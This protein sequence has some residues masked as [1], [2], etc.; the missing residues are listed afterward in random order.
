MITNN[1]SILL[2]NSKT[3]CDFIGNENVSV[4]E[5]VKQPRVCTF[6]P[7]KCADGATNDKP[8]CYIHVNDQALE[9]ELHC[10]DPNVN[11][12]FE[13]NAY[14]NGKV[15]SEYVVGIE[16]NAVGKNACCI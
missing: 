15:M 16:T 10:Y 13:V 2:F 7:T 12:E 1:S 8:R 4:S 3:T 5:G 14:M 9:E 6:T 11:V